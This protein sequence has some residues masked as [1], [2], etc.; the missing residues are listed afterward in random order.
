MYNIGCIGSRPGRIHNAAEG[1]GWQRKCPPGDQ[2]WCAAVARR[3]WWL[4]GGSEGVTEKG[5]KLWAPAPDRLP[6]KRRGEALPQGRPLPAGKGPKPGRG[7]EVGAPIFEVWGMKDG[8]AWRSTS[9]SE[10]ISS[11][12]EVVNP[13]LPLR[14]ACKRDC[15]S[16]SWA[17]TGHP[18]SERGHSSIY[19]GGGGDF[20]ILNKVQMSR[21]VA[22]V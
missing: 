6:G 20:S 19:G 3:P 4:A 17:R 8:G 5:C 14:A 2:H 10:D 16:G 15:R 12:G 13:I 7:G 18:S 9:R 1:L 11:L 21:R 22:L